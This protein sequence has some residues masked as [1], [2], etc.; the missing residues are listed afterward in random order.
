[1]NAMLTLHPWPLSLSFAR[2]LQAPAL[3]PWRGEPSNIAAAQ[4][5][6]LHRARCNSAARNGQYAVELESAADALPAEP[7]T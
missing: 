6:F 3:E 1:M 4:R 2:A 7:R 5:A